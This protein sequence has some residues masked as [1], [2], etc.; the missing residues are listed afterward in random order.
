[1]YYNEVIKEIARLTETG[2]GFGSVQTLYRGENECFPS[3]SSG[4]Y[5]YF[6]GHDAWNAKNDD[7]KE[8]FLFNYEK[9]I[10]QYASIFAGYGDEDYSV[11][12]KS[13]VED[14]SSKQWELLADVQHRGGITNF[15]DFTRD[16][17]I[18]LFFACYS[19]AD[20]PWIQNHLRDNNKDGRII[21]YHHVSM[22]P[23]H[24]VLNFPQVAYS[25]IQSGVLVRPRTY[26][27]MDINESCID[28]ITIPAQKKREIWGYLAGLCNIRLLT[29]YSDL[30]GYVRNQHL[31]FP[32]LKKK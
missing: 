18:A 11:E 31:L 32:K 16:V 1:M 30:H 27:I 13:C 25:R 15:I 9:K 6:L 23:K 8:Q 12:S 24:D 26:G 29:I 17:N 3:I 10:V 2:R 22:Q 14:F 21:L 5:R 28:I 19:E 20:S 4:L 7:E